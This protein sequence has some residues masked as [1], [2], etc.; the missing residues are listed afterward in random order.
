MRGG[1]WDHEESLF[2]SLC[3][4]AACGDDSQLL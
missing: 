4:L 3:L 1:L 2:H